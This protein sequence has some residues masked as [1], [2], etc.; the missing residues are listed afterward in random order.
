MVRGQTF[1]P[2]ETVQQTFED[3]TEANRPVEENK[4]S[5]FLRGQRMLTCT[6]YHTGH[7]FRILFYT[8]SK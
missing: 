6:N 5:L 2:G 1:F 8:R 7:P 4:L 3:V